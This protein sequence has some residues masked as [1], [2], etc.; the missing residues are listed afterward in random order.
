MLKSKFIGE[1]QMDFFFGKDDDSET[2]IVHVRMDPTAEGAI[3]VEV[4]LGS[5]SENGKE[6]VV[7]FTAPGLNND[8]VFY[9]D[10]NG[11]EM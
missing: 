5:L 6:V 7:K 11:L 2:M 8:G 9:S 4:D 1:N 3:V 10:A